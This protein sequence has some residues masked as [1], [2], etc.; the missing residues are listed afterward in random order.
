[1]LMLSGIGPADHLRER[2]VAVVHDAP[3]VGANLQNH[4]GYALRYACS[5]PITAYRHLHPVRAARAALD[6][7]VGGGGPLGESYVATGGFFR[8]DPS[9]G[10]SDMIVVMAPGLVRRAEMGAKVWDILPNEH[11]FQIS[12]A[13][14]RPQTKGDVRLRSANPAD[15]PLISPR[16]FEEPD[17]MRR[18]VRGVQRLR[19]MMRGPAMRD[20]ISNELQPGP[21]CLDDGAVE[22]E[23]RERSINYYHPS[24]TCRMGADETSVVDPQLRVRGVE[25]L[26]VADASVMPSPLCAC[27]HAP[28]IMIG[29]KAAALIAGGAGVP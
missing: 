10:V 11:G 17:D 18:L 4:P 5:K 3:Q 24:G 25:G 15:P 23:I 7:A 12:V 14:G 29:E 19:D 22:A 2:G 1:M 16:Y 13:I 6:Y 20:V 9:D 21:E 28:A 27:T 26:R 8:T